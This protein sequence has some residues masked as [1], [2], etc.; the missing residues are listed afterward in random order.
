MK[1]KTTIT[2]ILFVLIG[3]APLFGQGIFSVYNN[4]SD[5]KAAIGIQ[6]RAD[7]FSDLKQSKI[8]NNSNNSI[9]SSGNETQNAEKP[10]GVNEPKEKTD[11]NSVKG[12]IESKEK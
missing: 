5:F 2:L 1:T 6:H 10:N 11:L 9:G 12:R 3:V 7:D 4:E 8:K